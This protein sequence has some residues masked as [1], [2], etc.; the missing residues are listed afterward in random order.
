MSGDVI[1]DLGVCGG[2]VCAL[3][4]ADNRSSVSGSCVSGDVVGER[5]EGGSVGAVG[6]K[7][8]ARVVVE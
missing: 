3:R 4:A 5:G 1:G 2:V 8:C 7:V 6:G